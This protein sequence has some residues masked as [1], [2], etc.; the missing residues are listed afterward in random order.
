MR[1]GGK[2]KLAGR[3][4]GGV[5]L[6]GLSLEML[7]DQYR[8]DLFDD[9]LPFMEK[10]VIDHQ[11]GGFMC[12]ID[13]NG[14]R[15]SARKETWFEGRGIWVYSFLYRNFG[16]HPEHLEVANKSLQF[17]LKS[18]P[19]DTDAL[20]PERFSREGEPLT[21]PAT[22][23]YGD[24]FIAEGLAEYSRASG[25]EKYWAIAKQIILKCVRIYDSPGYEPNIVA[26]Y[27]APKALP[28]PGARIQGVSMV[29]VRII[30]QMLEVREDD[31]LLGV[32]SHCVDAV[33]N[34]HYN[35]EFSLNNEFLN[36]DF[37]RPDN[38]LA[39]FVYTGHA[40]ETLWILLFEAARL[41]D[42]KLFQTCAE[43]FERHV[44]VAWDDVYGGVFRSLNSV[45]QNLWTLDKVLWAQEEVLIG[46]LFLYEL[47]GNAWAGDMFG[48]M[49]KY[50]HEK[51]PRKQHGSPLWKSA[52]DRK[53]APQSHFT[54]E[55]RSTLHL[56]ALEH[57]HHPRHLML[58]LMCIERMIRASEGTTGPSG[59]LSWH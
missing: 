59:G 32:V 36:H 46:S 51:Y 17:I 33:L 56:G 42:T 26:S 24:L 45:E 11:Y 41:E 30:S 58:N 4:G 14:N 29:L 48:K 20:W 28:F 55:A 15:L 19:Q 39:Q 2:T 53:V 44:E 21:P 23:I 16:K 31:E 57:Y 49:F 22:S 5:E 8:Q 10:Y 54:S 35:P 13:E 43:R 37:S 40:I 18:K 6:G 27:M 38:E 50:V 9:F 47:T 1:R 12:D 3:Q 34:H 52:A 7:R 25:E